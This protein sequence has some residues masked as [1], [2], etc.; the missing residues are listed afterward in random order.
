M[1]QDLK[2]ENPVIL[3][4]KIYLPLKPSKIYL[5]LKNVHETSLFGVCKVNV[6]VF[7]VMVLYV[8]LFYISDR[9]DS[10]YQQLWPIRQS[11]PAAQS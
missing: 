2:E 4:N 6:K 9:Y 3:G 10:D 8:S 11:H 1:S 5:L 7:K